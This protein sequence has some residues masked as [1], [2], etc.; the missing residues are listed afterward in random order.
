MNSELRIMYWGAAP[1]VRWLELVIAGTCDGNVEW[2]GVLKFCGAFLG[3]AGNFREI[4]YL[5][6]VV[7][8]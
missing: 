6:E 7:F 3:D 5:R 2:G 1:A 8:T 4:R